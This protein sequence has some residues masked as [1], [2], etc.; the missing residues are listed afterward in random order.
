MDEAM[1]G[2]SRGVDELPPGKIKAWV[3][4]NVPEVV[5][6]SNSNQ[7]HN[8]AHRT[9]T[10]QMKFH[11]GAAWEDEELA[12]GDSKSYDTGLVE[13]KVRNNGR[14]GLTLSYE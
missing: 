8:P 6:V 5:R 2:V 14:A 3:L 11:G 12:W 1:P 9:V 13:M 7:A 10:F 4:P